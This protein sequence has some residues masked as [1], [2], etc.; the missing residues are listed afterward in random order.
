MALIHCPECDN[1]ISNTVRKCP[2]CGFVLKKTNYKK[3]IILL[4][5]FCV[6][7]AGIYTAYHFLIYTPQHIPEQAAELLAKG[8]YI[9]ADRLYARL[10]QTDEIILLREQLYYES[11]IVAATKAVQENL[12]FPDTIIISEVVIWPEE[13]QDPSAS[14]ETQEVYVNTEPKFLI[15]YLAKSKG[16]DMVDGYVIVYW[17]NGAYV[18]GSSLD[19]LTPLD[20]LPWY[21]DEDDPYA[22]RDFWAEQLKK[23]KI[24]DDLYTRSRVGTYDLTRC[25]DV[26]KSTFGKPITIIPTGDLIVTPTPRVVTVTP[27][28]E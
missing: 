7:L 21:I 22:V 11:R 27:K 17:E 19:E 2:S 25:G 20:S 14:T 9:G 5:A 12:I 24:V 15:H 26:V 3:W 10:P 23:G 4:A 13:I 18:A 6:L 16:G 8:D 1:L 28:P